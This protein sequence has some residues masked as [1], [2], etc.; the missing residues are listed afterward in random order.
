VFMLIAFNGHWKI[1]LLQKLEEG[2]RAGTKLTK[3]YILY[4]NNTVEFCLM[5]NNAFDILNMRNQFAKRTI[6]K[7][8]LTDKNY[9]LKAHTDNIIQY[10]SDFKTVQGLLILK[11]Y[12]K[13]GFLGFIICLK[14]TFE[15]WYVLKQLELNYLLTFKFNQNHL[16]TYFIAI[17]SRGG[18]NDN[19]NAQ[20]F[21]T[22]YKRLIVRHE[23]SALEKSNCLINDIHI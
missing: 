15:L 18:F 7:V 3:K 11:I 17:R 9:K 10:I 13:V 20:Q 23:I 21:Q 5:F 16:K 19:P 14:N 22:A 6:Y 1:V 12:R 2:L 4:Q 8:P